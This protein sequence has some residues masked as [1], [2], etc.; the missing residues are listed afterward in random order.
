MKKLTMTMLGALLSAAAFGQ[1]LLQCLDPHVA[2]GLLFEAHSERRLTITPTLHEAL[3]GVATP[4]GFTLVGTSMRDDVQ[5]ATVAYRTNRSGADALAA[6][7]AS[8][9]AAGWE[10]EQDETASLSR[11]VFSL[12]DGQ[13]GT[14]TTTVCR[15]GARLFARVL[16]IDDTRYPTIIVPGDDAPRACHAEN[17]E[18]AVVMARSAL[19]TDGIPAL[20]FPAGTRSAMPDGTLSSGGGTSGNNFSTGVRVSSP[21]SGLVLL[22]HFVPQMAEQGWKIEARWAG[23]VSTGGRWTRTSDDGTPYWATVE[24][25]ELAPNTYAASYY[26]LSPR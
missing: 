18:L 24:L 7:V 17:R 16:D 20:V 25:V 4:A 26:Q 21:D 10:Q 5:G 6:L 13:A 14:G 9:E 22:D 12:A 1:D 15:D 2:N 19:L 11:S 23:R 8:F 3:T